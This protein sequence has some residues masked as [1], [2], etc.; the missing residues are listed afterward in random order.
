MIAN[1]RID[2]D[3]RAVAILTEALRTL[4]AESAHLGT[5]RASTNPKYAGFA[6]A[7]GTVDVQQAVERAALVAELLEEQSEQE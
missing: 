5:P 7:R 3:P 1:L 6:L 2:G 4:L